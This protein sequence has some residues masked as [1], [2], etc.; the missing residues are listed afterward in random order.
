MSMQYRMML[1]SPPSEADSLLVSGVISAPPAHPTPPALHNPELLRR[2]ALKTKHDQK[3]GCPR[4]LTKQLLF[5]LAIIM[6]PPAFF[7]FL[8]SP[9]LQ[10]TL[11]EESKLLT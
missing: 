10:Y 9:A 1:H 7:E 5:L 4:R 3:N 2:P 11:T 6:Q 8:Q